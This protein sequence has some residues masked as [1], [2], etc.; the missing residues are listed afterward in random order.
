MNDKSASN[1]KNSKGKDASMKKN[2]KIGDFFNGLNKKRER[3]D[4]E[5]VVVA[6]SKKQKTEGN[7]FL[8]FKSQ[9]G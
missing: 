9:M 4:D 2:T 7:F 5:P 3:E 6:K 8:T 1:L